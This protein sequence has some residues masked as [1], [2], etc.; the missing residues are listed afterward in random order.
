MIPQANGVVAEEEFLEEVVCFLREIVVRIHRREALV[1]AAQVAG[2]GCIGVAL[3]VVVRAQD[4]LDSL[5]EDIVEE[6][7]DPAV[8]KVGRM[9]EGVAVE[10]GVILIHEWLCPEWALGGPARGPHS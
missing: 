10:F 6:F 5:V 8:I 7:V 4:D 9:R 2:E 3:K 1:S